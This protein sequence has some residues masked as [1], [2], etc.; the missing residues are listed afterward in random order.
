MKSFLAR[1]LPGS[2]LGCL[3][4]TLGA[5]PMPPHFYQVEEIPVPKDFAPEVGALAFNRSG[6]LVV[7]LRRHGILMAKPATD[8]AKFEWRVFTDASL[9]NPAGVYVEADNQLLVPQ[10]S[11]FL[12]ISDTDR[13]GS[14][15][16]F[17]S[18]CSEWGLSGNYHETIAGPIPDGL[19]NWFLAIGTAS[20]NGPTFNWVRGEF[21]EFG[22]RGRNFSSVAYKGWVVKVTPTGEM[23]PWASGFR[24]NNG[25]AMSPDGDLFVTDNQGDFRGTSPFYHIQKGNFY[26]HAS[27]LNWEPGFVE[28]NGDPLKFGLDK[29]D[30]MR[31]RAA[32]ELPQTLMCNSPSQPLFDTTGGKFGPFAGQ[33]FVGDVAG[34]RIL[35]MMLEKV[36][37][38]YQGAVVHFLVQT[39]L[40][41]GNNRLAWSPDGKSLYVG[42]TY[43]G[44][45][46]P[47]ETEGLQ[48]I[49]WQG[50]TPFEVITMSITR[51]G[52]DVTF[53]QPAARE[54][55]S[56]PANYSFQNYHYA[57]TQNYGGPQVDKKPIAVKQVRVSPDGL[58]ASIDLEEMTAK[59]IY[60]LDLG[61]VK[62]TQGVPL[63]NTTVC[64]TVNVLRN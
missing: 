6:E 13:D 9:H 50:N 33:V 20:L 45:G 31:T 27:S 10:M 39:G 8:P 54:L 35:R 24:A 60:Q 19:G 1:L 5:A 37:G 22:R 28:K 43:R 55:A 2:I 59:K 64:Y 21:S 48:R 42:Q 56:N 52:F 57:Y 4:V 40:R 53:T 26:G 46:G 62:S 61:G 44:W 7:V 32:I 14:A 49:V 12:R 41:G 3:A 34:Q 58:R 25:I 30:A 11:D 16:S 63:I 23:I 17:E 36:N 29:L 15:D 51:T 18:L 38:V 47:R